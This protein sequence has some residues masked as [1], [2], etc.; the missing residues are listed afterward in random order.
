MVSA[1]PVTKNSVSAFIFNWIV[2]FQVFSKKCGFHLLEE[3]RFW[4]GVVKQCGR[5]G[6]GSGVWG[7]SG[8]NEFRYRSLTY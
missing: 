6:F 3:L 1:F 2:R 5:P 8:V 4:E 7:G